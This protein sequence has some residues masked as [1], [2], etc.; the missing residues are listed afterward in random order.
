MCRNYQQDLVIITS[1]EPLSTYDG[2]LVLISKHY[3]FTYRY[4]EEGFGEAPIFSRGQQVVDT[5][6]CMR[7]LTE[8][9]WALDER[10]LVAKKR[11]LKLFRRAKRAAEKAESE[12]MLR[13]AFELT[14]QHMALTLLPIDQP[15]LHSEAKIPV[16]I[17]AH[18]SDCRMMTSLPPVSP[19]P[20]SVPKKV[21]SDAAQTSLPEKVEIDRTHSDQSSFVT[22]QVPSISPQAEVTRVDT[23]SQSTASVPQV[24]G[25]DETQDSLPESV[26]VLEWL[27]CF[28]FWCAIKYPNRVA[29]WICITRLG[30]KAN[31]RQQSAYLARSNDPSAE[32]VSRV[33]SQPRKVSV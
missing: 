2:W 10:E 27:G 25:S 14:K 30:S 9:M 22:E 13:V 17:P 15:K 12:R 19:A 6:K 32:N 33:P 11:P 18:S 5:S 24:A 4:R 21:T 29:A 8:F 23:A 20:A 26:E 16:A 3:G 7:Q 1:D 28:M 31:W